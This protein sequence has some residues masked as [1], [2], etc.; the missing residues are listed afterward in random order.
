MEVMEILALL[1]GP[2]CT[3]SSLT[4]LG[5]T[6]SDWENDGVAQ[7]TSASARHRDSPVREKTRIHSNGN[8]RGFR[9][10]SFLATAG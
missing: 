2:P 7:E 3:W 6:T 5:A 8:S 1:P 10:Y 9:L 4:V